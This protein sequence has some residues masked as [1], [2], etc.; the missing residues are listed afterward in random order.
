MKRR[1]V[2]RAAS[3][4]YDMTRAIPAP[5]MAA[6][7]AA[8]DVFTVSLVRMGAAISLPPL[9]ELPTSRHPCLIDRN[10]VMAE[11]IVRRLRASAS[12]KIFWTRA[13]YDTNG[14]NACRDH[15]A[16]WK[17]PNANG[18]VDLILDRIQDAIAEQETQGD[19]RVHFQEL[20]GEWEQVEMPEAPRRRDCEIA[21]RS[22]VL[23][24]SLLFGVVDLFDDAFA[25]LDIRSPRVG[26]RQ[27]ARRPLKQLSLQTRF[28]LGEPAANRRD[29]HAELSR[30][31]RQASASAIA[32]ITDINSM[33]SMRAGFPNTEKLFLTIRTAQHRHNRL[34]SARGMTQAFA[35]PELFHK[36]MKS[37][38]GWN[39]RTGPQK[40]YPDHAVLDFDVPTLVL[41]GGDVA[42]VR[43]LVFKN[44][45]G[46]KLIVAD[47]AP[48]V[49]GRQ[50]RSA[51]TPSCSLSR[52]L[53]PL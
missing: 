16:V 53:K 38:S 18:D 31:R 52:G 12:S 22:T 37:S 40:S 1:P 20:T 50:S 4:L 47:G 2:R 32:M 19:I 35:K 30:S 9:D 29:R 21:S 44:Q 6:S 10:A 42:D 46:V 41:E 28:E 24:R 45:E 3:I 43:P 51:S 33:R 7:T 17:R 13:G 15:A 39:L 8:S 25:R 26:K 14:S 5:A 49:W 27:V 11:K 48:T 23:A 36:P 34:A